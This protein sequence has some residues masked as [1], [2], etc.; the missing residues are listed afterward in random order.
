MALFAMH[1][2]SR[3]HDTRHVISLCQQLFRRLR[4]F[5]YYAAADTLLPS[6]FML[7]Y[8]A[9]CYDGTRFIT[10]SPVCCQERYAMF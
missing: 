9:S 8:A 6:L 3:R 2:A 10:F 5:R 7:R 4:Y 1:A